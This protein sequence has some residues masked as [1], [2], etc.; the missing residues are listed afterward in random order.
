MSLL[1]LETRPA[2]EPTMFGFPDLP[3]WVKDALLI[4]MVQNAA[5]LYHQPALWWQLQELSSMR[6]CHE[7]KTKRF[8]Y[9]MGCELSDMLV[10]MSGIS[11]HRLDRGIAGPHSLPS[12]DSVRNYPE[13]VCAMKQKGLLWYAMWAGWCVV[14]NIRYTGYTGAWLL[15][16]TTNLPSGG[17]DRNSPQSTCAI[18]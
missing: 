8:Y 10:R 13:C 14:Q 17:S 9:G 12:G 18:K 2:F 15:I 5:N 4:Q 6:V 11:V 16:S 7:T 1:W 3:K